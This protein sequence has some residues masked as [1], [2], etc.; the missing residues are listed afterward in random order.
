MSLVGTPAG[1]RVAGRQARGGLECRP[2]MIAA[3]L[4][5]S[6]AG[7]VAARASAGER[8][9]VPLMLTRPIAPETVR[10]LIDEAHAHYRRANLEHAV[11]AWSTALTWSP[12]YRAGWLQLGNLHYRRDDLD[13]A[14]SALRRAA[15]APAA[16][17]IDDRLPSTGEAVGDPGDSIRIKALVNLAALSLRRSALLL[18]QA[19]RLAAEQVR[20]GGGS[21]RESTALEAPGGDI[22]RRRTTGSVRASLEEQANDVRR[23]WQRIAGAQRRTRPDTEPVRLDPSGA[24]IGANRETVRRW[25]ELAPRV[26]V[27]YITGG[28]AK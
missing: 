4:I 18:D 8:A 3:V 11:D 14:E 2:R 12:A 13:A 22:A 24:G 9:S 19:D 23:R 27:D 17:A 16:D 21:D 10:R 5:A 15:S 28:P 1:A 25:P 6:L 26:E 7:L 20:R